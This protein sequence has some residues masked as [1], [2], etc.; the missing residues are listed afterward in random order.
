MGYKCC[1]QVGNRLT[2][3]RI[4]ARAALRPILD[5]TTTTLTYL[6]K[7]FSECEDQCR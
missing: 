5:S 3:A 6:F 7:K 1:L 4:L 2:R